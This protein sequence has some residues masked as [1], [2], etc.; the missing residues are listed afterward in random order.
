[1]MD[2]VLGG[3]VL[4]GIPFAVVA[5]GAGWLRWNQRAAHL[6]IALVFSLWFTLLQALGI[7][8]ARSVWTP[9]YESAVLT[10]LVYAMGVLDRWFLGE[11]E[12]SAARAE[13]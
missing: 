9:S 12:R 4:H 6:S 3:T 2:R 8:E 13:T 10:M 5:F 11:S 1:M 7:W